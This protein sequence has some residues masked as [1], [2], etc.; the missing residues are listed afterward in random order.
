MQSD[1]VEPRSRGRLLRGRNRALVIGAAA[2]ALVV[3]GAAAGAAIVST[4]G[5]GSNGTSAA[6]ETTAQYRTTTTAAS[7]T[8]ALRQTTVPS[9]AAPKPVPTTT[10]PRLAISGTV[11]YLSDVSFNGSN[12]GEPWQLLANGSAC[13]AR[14]GYSDLVAGGSVVITGATGA[15]LAVA[16]LRPGQIVNG[17]KNTQTERAEREKLLDAIYDLRIAKTSDPVEQAQLRLDRADLR[18]NDAEH[19]GSSPGPFEGHAFIA[20]WCHLDFVSPL[21]PIGAT[22]NV[23]VTHRGTTAFSAQQVQGNAGRV[24]LIIGN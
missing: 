23:T 1:P 7:S 21:L 15:A 5:S 22:Y 8:T 24:I 13:P 6:T 17:V 3:I 11:E 4:R 10:A 16:S 20:T 19:P 12:D 9:T 2:V 18:L 14:D